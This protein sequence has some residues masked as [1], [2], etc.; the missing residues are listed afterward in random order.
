MT[1]RSFAAALSGL[2]RLRSYPREARSAKHLG[3]LEALR[4]PRVS[5][6]TRHRLG[7]PLGVQHERHRPIFYGRGATHPANGP[8]DP[9]PFAFV[10]ALSVSFERLDRLTTS[11][12]YQLTYEIR[13][14]W[15]A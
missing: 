7:T 11:V 5:P 3:R 1:L 10:S 2:V 6:L 4:W 14:L 12:R 15:C 9:A 8:V 13:S